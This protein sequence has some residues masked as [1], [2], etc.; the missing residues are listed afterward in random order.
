MRPFAVIFL[1]EHQECHFRIQSI[2]LSIKGVQ[3]RQEQHSTPLKRVSTSDQ[4]TPKEILKQISINK[5]TPVSSKN[6]SKAPAGG[7]DSGKIW[8]FFPIL[9]GKN[10]PVVDN[11]KKVHKR[12]LPLGPKTSCITSSPL[13]ETRA[14]EGKDTNNNN[15]FSI[16]NHQISTFS[17]KSKESERNNK[18]TQ[19]AYASST[20]I[21]EIITKYSADR[22]RVQEDI[23]TTVNEN[24]HTQMT[25]NN[26]S[27]T[28]AFEYF[29][30]SLDNNHIT[31]NANCSGQ[32]STFQSSVAQLPSQQGSMIG[33]RKVMRVS[34]FF[35]DLLQSDGENEQ[36]RKSP[37]P[38]KSTNKK[39]YEP[40]DDIQSEE[41][42]HKEP[43]VIFNSGTQRK[44]TSTLVWNH[45]LE[46]ER[47]F[48]IMKKRKLTDGH[49]GCMFDNSES[50]IIFKKKNTDTVT[51]I[52]AKDEQGHNNN[53]KSLGIER[54]LRRLKKKKEQ[55]R[56]PNQ[57]QE[58]SC[59]I[60]LGEIFVLG[61]KF[62]NF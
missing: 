53:S 48:M 35:T 60:C 61:I 39:R 38:M 16:G 43:A 58:D 7:G 37:A 9:E 49:E 59:P 33:Q 54:K 15:R 23:E 18:A 34:S 52:E 6:G 14:A 22:A 25:A 21:K 20:K 1:R 56:S 19:K 55:Q 12:A 50:K 57:S 17:Q 42:E 24:H 27:C 5:S 31:S 3:K 10:E 32:L 40:F 30:L 46:D 26:E 8:D 36:G 41:E 2:S 44:K 4:A 29:N 62:L 11:T 51:E 45:P 47:D 28:S 13:V